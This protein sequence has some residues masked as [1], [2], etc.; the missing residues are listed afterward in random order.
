MERRESSQALQ[1]IWIWSIRHELY[2]CVL[3]QLQVVQETPSKVNWGSQAELDHKGVEVWGCC[4][5][6]SSKAQGHRAFL[7][8][9]KHKIGPKITGI[10]IPS[11]MQSAARKGKR[12][13]RLLCGT[14]IQEWLEAEDG[15]STN[16]EKLSSISPPL[17]VCETCGTWKA[18]I[19]IATTTNRYNSNKA[20]QFQ[21]TFAQP[22]IL[23]AWQEGYLSPFPSFKTTYHSFCHS[24]AI[25]GIP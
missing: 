3:P 9:T 1:S 20:V 15:W 6:H 17:E 21:T 4:K 16:W 10:P 5:R 18:T 22:L 23:M 24:T 14:D 12:I 7:R 11:V 19:A 8:L 25:T 2:S 13:R